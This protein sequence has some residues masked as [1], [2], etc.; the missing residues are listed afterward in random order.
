MLLNFFSFSVLVC[1]SDVWENNF[2]WIYDNYCV[3][4]KCKEII[5]CAHVKKRNLIVTDL[6][7][8]RK[9]IDKIS[10]T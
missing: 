7:S 6:Y 8:L 2:T 3:C 4:T 1:M 10:I 9:M 5:L